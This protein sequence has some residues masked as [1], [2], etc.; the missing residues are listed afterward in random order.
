MGFKGLSI[1]KITQ[2]FL[3]GEIPTLNSCDPSIEP[4][5]TPDVI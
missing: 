1:K 5:G 4:C 2:I 3:Y